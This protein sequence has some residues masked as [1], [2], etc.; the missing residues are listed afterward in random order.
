MRMN[1]TVSEVLQ[2]KD[3]LLVRQIADEIKWP[4][5]NLFDEMV[6]GFR[7]KGIFSACGVFKPQVNIP[8]L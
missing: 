5:E 4:D 6:E 1:E 7:L 8:S 3:I 2:G